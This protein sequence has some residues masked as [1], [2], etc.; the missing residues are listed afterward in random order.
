MVLRS[1]G[2]SMRPASLGRRRGGE[3]DGKMSSGR[4]KPGM[5]VC[6]IYVYKLM[7]GNVEGLAY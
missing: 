7:A 5:C 4:L 6:G 1:S 3:E 2:K